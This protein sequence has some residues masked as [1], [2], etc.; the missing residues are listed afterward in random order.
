MTFL[1]LILYTVVRAIVPPHVQEWHLVRCLRSIKTNQ[2]TNK[3][4]PWLLVRKRTIPTD[5]SHF[6]MKFSA[7]ICG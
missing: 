6:S 3:Q 5:D 7:N 2:Q 4:T 1:T